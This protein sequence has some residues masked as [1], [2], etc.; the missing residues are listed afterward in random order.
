MTDILITPELSSTQYISSGGYTANLDQDSSGTLILSAQGSS[1]RKDLFVI[2]GSSGRIFTVEDDMTGSLFSVNT[3]DGLCLFD[4]IADHTVKFPYLNNVDTSYG[5]KYNPATKIITYALD[6]GGG[7]GGTQGIQ[8]IQGIQGSNG[9][10]GTLYKTFTW[11]IAAPA[12]GYIPGPRLY[13][14]ATALR[15]SSYV[16]NAT[17]VT[18]NIEERASA[19]PNTA[20]TDLLSSDQ[21][22]TTSGTSTIS[23]ANS[24]LA[25]NNHLSLHISAVSGTPGI[26]CITIAVE[27][28]S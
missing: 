18:F 11:T 20:G 15:I 25:G 13:V 2:N 8:G 10:S 22:A 17:S 23:F 4:V 14:N 1:N 12:V 26:V 6:T 27:H 9:I 28:Q 16:T 19:T 24:S 21:V 5:I 7:G 3:S